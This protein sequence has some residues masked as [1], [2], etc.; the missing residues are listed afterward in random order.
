MLTTH[1]EAGLPSSPQFL[2]LQVYTWGCGSTGAGT[3]CARPTALDTSRSEVQPP[4]T[5]SHPRR[6]QGAV[7][8]AWRGASA[9]VPLTEKGLMKTV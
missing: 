7:P 9:R 1:L 4:R 2:A 3:V 5:E 6:A 8:Q